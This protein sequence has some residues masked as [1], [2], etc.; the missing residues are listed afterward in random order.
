[1]RN[2]H[3][4]KLQAC[5]HDKLKRLADGRRHEHSWRRD[6][7][8]TNHGGKSC[9]RTNYR[10]GKT[11]NRSRGD[12]TTPHKGPA[13]KPCHVYGPDS[14]HLYDECGANPK[15]QCSASNN[16]SKRTQD[17]HF[18]N[19]RQHESGKDSRQDTPRAPEFSDGEL[20]ASAAASPI[21][22]YHLE[23][24]HVPKKRRMGDVPHKSPGNKALV[25]FGSDTKK[26]ERWMSLNFAMDDLF[27]DDVSMDLF[28][29]AIRGQTD[30]SGLNTCYVKTNAFF[31]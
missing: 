18:N 6:R 16:Y 10:K 9:K 29:Q 5:Y 30:G 19:N 7:D 8:D 13:K 3:R 27:H 24:F 1:M 23:T 17:T 28:I 20:S 22:N 4:H 25:S 31:N 26:E 11:D 12:C 15:N 21:K 2:K 14:K